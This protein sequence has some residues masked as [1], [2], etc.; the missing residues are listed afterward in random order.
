MQNGASLGG[1][2]VNHCTHQKSIGWWPLSHPWSVAPGGALFMSFSWYFACLI[3][4]EALSLGV[5]FFQGKNQLDYH[6]HYHNLIVAWY[7]WWSIYFLEKKF[8]FCVICVNLDVLTIQFALPYYFLSLE[9]LP[10]NVQTI[11]SP[12]ELRP[13]WLIH[14]YVLSAILLILVPKL[15]IDKFQMITIKQY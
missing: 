8:N 2:N 10:C 6:W 11:H 13:H 9:L 3:S 5:V 15:I 14:L 7:F 4:F 1:F 12:K